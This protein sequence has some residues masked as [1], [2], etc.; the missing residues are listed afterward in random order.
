MLIRQFL[1]LH[2]K[3]SSEKLTPYFSN[4]EIIHATLGPNESK[5]YLKSLEQDEH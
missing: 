2:S 1:C 4:R 3:D 5:G